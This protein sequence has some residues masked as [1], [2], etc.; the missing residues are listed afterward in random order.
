M[1]VG[2]ADGPSSW[3]A[4]Q[5]LGFR[6]SSTLRCTTIR[7]TRCLTR[8]APCGRS[9]CRTCTSRC[10]SQRRAKPISWRSLPKWRRTKGESFGFIARPTIVFLR[11]SGCTASLNK[12]RSVS[13]HSN[14]CVAYGNRTKFGLPSSKPCLPNMTANPSIERTVNSVL[15][16]LLMSNVSVQ[17]QR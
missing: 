6:S 11:F 3:R 4:S 12:G 16:M 14:S 10:N 17:D 7:V 13:K 8:R 1:H 5:L 2:S 9:V 15:R